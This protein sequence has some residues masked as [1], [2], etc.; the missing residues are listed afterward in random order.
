VNT[1]EEKDFFN[2]IDNSQFD[3]VNRMAK[4]NPTLLTAYHY[5]CFGGT[6]LTV[7]ANQQEYSMIDLLIDLGA[8]VNQASDWWAG[9]WNPIQTSLSCGN[10]KLAKHFVDQGAIVG[11]HEAAGLDDMERLTQLLIKDPSLVH[12]RGGDGCLPLHFAASREIVDILINYGA[13][14]DAR[15]IDHYSTASQYLAPH[16]P[17][18]VKYLF[19]KGAMPDIFTLAMIGDV[20]KLKPIILDDPTLLHKVINQEFFPPSPAHDVHNVLSFTVGGNSNLLHTA[21]IGRQVDMMHY[22]VNAGI[23]VDS[24]GGYDKSTA[25]HMVAWRDYV[26]VAQQLVKDGANIDLRSGEIHNN[27]PAGWAIVGGSPDVFCFLIDQGAVVQDY[28]E[29]DIRAGLNGEFQKYK[30]VPLTNFERMLEK[31]SGK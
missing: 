13:D 1:N 29:S 24:R 23:S 4:A 10:Y 20:D 8:D 22:L 6:P 27:T 17:Q 30:Q 9:P 18:V 11:A 15:D 7:C 28:F 21:A 5:N 25:M 2:A 14:L 16:Q 19:E 26:D 3:E 31:I 12:Q